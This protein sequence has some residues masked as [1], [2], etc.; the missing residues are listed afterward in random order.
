MYVV[1]II[2]K[3][4]NFKS[5]TEAITATI[6]IMKIKNYWTVGQWLIA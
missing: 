1:N 4:I 3:K 6:N 5:I 2:L